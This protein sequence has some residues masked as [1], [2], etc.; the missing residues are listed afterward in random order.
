MLK[1]IACRQ[2]AMPS[3]FRLMT[4][5]VDHIYNL[6]KHF[7]G[8]DAEFA[9]VSL[10]IPS[11]RVAIHRIAKPTAPR[12]KWSGLIPWILEEK[13][14]QPVEKTHFIIGNNVIDELVD[15]FAV[16][17]ED[18]STWVSVARN[19]G[20]APIQMTPDYFAVPWED[21]RINVAWREGFCLVRYSLSEGFSAQPDL[22]WAMIDCLIRDAKIPP[23]L[24]I[25]LPNAQIIPQ[26]LRDRAEVNN[27]SQDWKMIDMSSE[28]NLLSGDYRP[29][30]AAPKVNLWQL[31]FA[32]FA[33]T[34]LLLATYLNVL[35]ANLQA[36]LS[37]VERHLLSSFDRVFLGHDVSPDQIRSVGLKEIARL[38]MQDQTFNT[39]PFKALIS[40]GKLM[41]NCECNL[42]SLKADGQEISIHV[43]GGEKLLTKKLSIEGYSLDVERGNRKKDDL[44]MVIRPKSTS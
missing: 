35:S 6:D 43:E 8:D 34:I 4:V 10:W 28:V 18:L 24:S 13:I 21:G 33:I 14:L 1:C 40:L 20:F 31:N 5:L 9:P 22:A 42:V 12:R 25:S 41:D 11:E 16:S 37:A 36:D 19:A 44:K 3:G 32:G 29:N 26:H 38:K 17:K 7:R 27:A 30:L 2:R 39:D 15:V 23:R